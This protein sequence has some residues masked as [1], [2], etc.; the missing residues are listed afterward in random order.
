M[1]DIHEYYSEEKIITQSQF[2]RYRNNQDTPT[3]EQLISDEIE[4]ILFSPQKS[5]YKTVRFRKKKLDIGIDIHTPTLYCPFGDDKVQGPDYIRFLLSVYPDTKDLQKIRHIIV[6]PRFVEAG[7]VEVVALY[8][9]K[10]AT[11]SLYIS[12]PQNYNTG[13][14]NFF[15]EKDLGIDVSSITNPH[16]LGAKPQDSKSHL[17]IPHLFYILKMIAYKKDETIDK[18]LLKIDQHSFNENI[19]LYKKISNFYSQQGY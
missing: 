8:F 19:E 13:N 3:F 1:F 12:T 18:F 4:H 14:L 2:S 9:P 11:L 15:E 10:P 6:R 7:G 16:F 17:T 5:G